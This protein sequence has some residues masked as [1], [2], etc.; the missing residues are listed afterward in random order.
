MLFEEERFIGK[1]GKTYIL[2]SPQIADA[3]KMIKYLKTAAKETEYGL[4]YPEELDFSIQ[5]EEDFIRRFSDDAN[6]I[7]IS[8]FDGNDLVGTA[9]LTRVLDKKKT[10]HRAEFGIALLKKV[11]G[12]GLG[13]KVVSELA[14]FAKKADFDQ[15]ELE[16]ASD[17]IAAVNLYK[18]LGFV[19]YGERP[20][21]M[22]LKNG[23]Y[24]DELLM[25]LKLK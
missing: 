23:N 4:S 10:M 1:D 22:K 6:S 13:F 7:M 2:R 18:K 19:V 14:A 17:N 15:V 12:Q 9:S 11:W 8:V 5:E 24:L 16:V 20:H 21:S 3:E 25:I